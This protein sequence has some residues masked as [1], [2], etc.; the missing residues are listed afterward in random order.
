[1]ARVKGPAIVFFNGPDKFFYCVLAVFG[2]I[3]YNMDRQKILNATN[4]QADRVWGTLCE[5]RPRLVRYNPPKI[6]LNGRLWRTA[7]RCFQTTRTVDLG[8]K[9]FEHSR[10]YGIIMLTVIVPHELIHQADFDLYGESEK[11][12]GH[13]KNWRKLMLEYGLPDNPFH[14]MEIKR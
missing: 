5:L 11:S 8:V 12:C 9:F 3:I 2:C 1:L 7:G 13:G 14:S 10:D 4:R 6:V